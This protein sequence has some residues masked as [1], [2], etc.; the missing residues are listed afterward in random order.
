MERF[1]ANVSPLD[2]PLEQAPEVLQPVRVD[3]AP[4]VALGMV[5]ELMNVFVIQSGV[6][7]QRIRVDVRPRFDVGPDDRL[8]RLAPDVVQYHRADLA[9]VR[10]VPGQKAHNG[11]LTRTVRPGAG[12]N[13]LATIRVHEFGLAT[14][15]GF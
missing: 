4:R 8:D 14:D 10:A 7:R 9:T 11:R 6:T 13:A 3:R 1:D 12:H 15:E 2:A 5:D